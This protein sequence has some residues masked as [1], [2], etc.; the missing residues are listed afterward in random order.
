MFYVSHQGAVRSPSLC[1]KAVKLWNWYVWHSIIIAAAFLLAVQNT[2]VDTLSRTFLQEHDWEMDP[3]VLH[4]V[5]C[6]WRVRKI[7]LFAMTKTKNAPSIAPE[8][9]WDI[10]CYEML[11][12]FTGIQISFMLFLQF[13]AY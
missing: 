5:F 9:V 7:D 6:H 2:T 10:I 12:S 11:S 3:V 13:L 8:P 1:A 4:N